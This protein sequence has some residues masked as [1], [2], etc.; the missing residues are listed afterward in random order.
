MGDLLL[1]AEENL[2][3]L[4][5]GQVRLEADFAP[6]V[7]LVVIDNPDRHN[8]LSGKMMVEFRHIVLWLETSAPEDM[9]A[10]IVTGSAHKSFC[11]GLDLK[12]AREH[13]ASREGLVDQMNLVMNDALARFARL[14]LITVGSIAGP[15]LG[16]GT[17]LITAFDYICM[18]SGTY[19]RFL[20]TRMGITSPWGGARRLV[21]SIGRKHALLLLAGAPKVTAEEA[22]VMGLVTVVVD[23]PAQPEIMTMYDACLRAS[24]AFTRQFVTDD[25]TGRR[26]MPAAVRGMKKLVVRAD[27]E[28]EDALLAQLKESKL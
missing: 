8:A 6:G 3:S 24:L 17:E 18:A 12:F 13:I 9:V 28:R 11:A 21:N 1:V 10:V 4:G 22:K 14:G 26:V 5:T 7:A 27:L 2:R 23:R 20:Q 25:L 16:G 15:A 19:L